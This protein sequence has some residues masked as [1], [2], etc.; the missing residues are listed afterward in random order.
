MGSTTRY[1]LRWPE[2]FAKVKDG[3][4]AIRT[5]AEDVEAALR[6]PL[7]V[8]DGSGTTSWSSK[9]AEIG[10][11]VSDDPD[12]KR[13]TW[14]STGV[15]DQLVLPPVTGYYLVACSVRFGGKAEADWFEEAPQ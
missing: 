10:W 14:R 2:N 3:A 7:L 15:A 13:G 6:P 11:D 8:T 9:A 5:L 4:A 1:G 12:R